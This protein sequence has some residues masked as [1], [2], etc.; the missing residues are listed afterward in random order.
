MT[1]FIAGFI[2][3]RDSEEAR[4]ISRALLQKR[5]VS[6]CNIV[7]G[8]E[9]LYWWKGRMREEGEALIILK[10]RKERMEE[11]IEEVKK[12]H[13]YEV[14]AIDFI[15]IEGGSREFLE[16]IGKETEGVKE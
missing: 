7:P 15:R 1:E 10:T 13:S 5:L 9:S 11:I 2:T 8:I 12:I 3:C 4:K 16:W 6:C 14:P